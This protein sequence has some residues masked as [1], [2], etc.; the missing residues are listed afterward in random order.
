M[1]PYQLRKKPKPRRSGSHTPAAHFPKGWDQKRADEVAHH[2]DHQSD[3][4]AVAEAEAGIR[5]GGFTMM[6]IPIELVPEVKKLLAKR[7]G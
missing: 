1:S 6:Q 3:V 7:A 5:A 2:Y 4:E